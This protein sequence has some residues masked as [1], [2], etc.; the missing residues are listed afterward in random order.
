M[1]RNFLIILV[2]A[3]LLSACGVNAPP[4][5]TVVSPSATAIPEP[6]VLTVVLQPNP[7]A[8]AK[9]DVYLKDLKT[10]EQKLFLT[11]DNVYRE[12]YHAAEVHNGNVYIILRTGDVNSADGNWTDELWRYDAKGQGTKLYSFKGLNFRTAPDESYTA[13]PQPDDD[14]SSLTRKVVFIDPQGK[15]VHEVNFVP[16]GDVNDYY[17]AS[18]LW[19]DNSQDY[20]DIAQIGPAPQFAFHINVT[21]WQLETYPLSQLN[22]PDEHDLNANTGQLVYSDYPIFFDATGSEQFASS[23]KPVTLSVYDFKS[24]KTQ[25]IATSVAKKFEPKWLPDNSIEYN[26]PNGTGRIVFVYK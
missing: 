4:P 1:K 6:T 17:P 26:D 25:V 15:V 7:Q 11:L 16:D 20:W 13:L 5:A 3:I 24:Q 21:S 9:T 2:G 19:S 18:G 8:D 23:G 12:H 10:G 22:I 14:Q